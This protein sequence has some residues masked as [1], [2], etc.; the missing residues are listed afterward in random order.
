[1]LA[2]NSLS[3]RLNAIKRGKIPPSPE[4]N[5][6]LIES[7]LEQKNEAD[8]TNAS[9]A[10]TVVMAMLNI[11]DVLIASV[12]YGYGTKVLYSLFITSVDWNFIEVLGLGF[13]LNNAYVV[14]LNIYKK[15]TS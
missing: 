4:N 8:Y 7:L 12:L 9:L 1:M 5:D 15:F 6:K 10:V 3:N 14:L 11:F 2:D 13:L